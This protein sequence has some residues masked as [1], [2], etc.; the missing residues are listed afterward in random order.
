MLTLN[1]LPKIKSRRQKR[2]GR[3]IGSG[4]GGH[5]VGRGQK[6]QKV[7]GKIHPLFDGQK[8]KK[9]LIQRLPILRGKGKLKGNVV[10]AIQVE[11]LNI[12]QDGTT[13]TTD[14]LLEKKLVGT[15]N[16]NQGVKIV[17]GGKLNRRL[18]VQIPTSQGAMKMIEAQGGETSPQ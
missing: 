18:K 8:N 16:L 5:T 9:S 12:F 15:M 2:V 4:K 1:L 13:V 17:V 11:K 6:G 7:R 14:A 10:L 3:G